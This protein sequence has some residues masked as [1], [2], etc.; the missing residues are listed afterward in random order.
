MIIKDEFT[1]DRFLIGFTVDAVY[2]KATRTEPE[3]F[4]FDVLETFVG[5]LDGTDS[6]LDDYDYSRVESIMTEKIYNI[7]K[8]S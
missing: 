1:F 2:S 4:D 6:E 8:N 3:Y 7:L 5:C